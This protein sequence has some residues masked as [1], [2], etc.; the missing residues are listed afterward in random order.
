LTALDPCKRILPF[1]LKIIA[2]LPFGFLLNFAPDFMDSSRNLRPVAIWLFSGC[3]LIALMV[4]VGGITRLTQSGL[5]IVDWRPVTGILPPLGEAQWETEFSKYKTSPEFQYLNSEFSLSDF[6]SI[7]WWEYIHRLIGR[8]IGVVFLI[9]FI[10]FLVQKKLRG[11]LLRNSLILFLLGGLQGFI[12]WIMV[13]SGLQDNPHVSHYRL[14]LHLMTALILFGITLWF[15]L[16]ITRPLLHEETPQKSGLRRSL[17]ILF[18]LVFIQI[19]YGA[20]VA[21]LKAGTAYP[22]F[23]LMGESLIPPGFAEGFETHGML[24]L[25]ELP[26]AVQFI[27]RTIA[28]VIFF[29]SMYLFIKVRRKDELSGFQSPTTWIFIITV[30]QFT[31]GVVTI[32]SG[33]PV[34]MGV[35]HQSG[36]LLLW[37]AV[38]AGLHAVR[39]KQ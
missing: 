1:G 14:A 9:P 31:L 27:H 37:T 12:G 5:S 38:W 21:G 18:V 19:V 4:V 33:V 16:N 8:L 7:F 23:P 26:I 11:T 13:K 32:L 35:L 10:L 36:A 34:I 20:F 24:N 2:L 25:A 39:K 22:T 3:L 30:L 17:K 29:F 28:W 6:K 15:G